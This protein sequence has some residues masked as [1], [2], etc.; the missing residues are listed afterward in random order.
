[1]QKSKRPQTVWDAI[2][3]AVSFLS[4]RIE[5]ARLD[6]ELILAYL[7]EMDRSRLYGNFYDSLSDEVWIEFTKLIATREQGFPLQYIIGRQEFMSLDLYVNEKVLI[8]R[9]DTEV[10]VE[11]AIML[12]QGMDSPWI[13]DMCTGSGAIA[14]SLAYYLPK[15][16]VLAV[17]I[18]EDAI[19]VARKNGDKLNLNHRVEWLQGNLFTPLC[20]RKKVHSSE[21][22]FLM[23]IIVSNPPYIPREE[24]GK[25]QREVADYE[26]K[27]ALDGGVDGLDFYRQIIPESYNYLK[28]D[29]Y[30]LLEIGMEQSRD[31]KRIF[32]ASWPA[33]EIEIIQDFAGHDRVVLGKKLN[34][35]SYENSSL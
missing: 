11:K 14:L 26:P 23:D 16:K 12:M 35:R 7:L 9:G 10:L 29:G 6:S 25:L 22:L 18:S 32:Q 21:E 3:W 27:L 19:R 17:D 5:S 31:V 33:V 34:R 20:E 24:I 28:D 30:L 4:P 2:Q 1:M 15:S 13:L 8:P